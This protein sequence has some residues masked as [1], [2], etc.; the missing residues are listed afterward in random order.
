M[1]GEGSRQSSVC[2][3]L[4]LKMRVDTDTFIVIQ[5]HSM[6][7]ITR[8]VAIATMAGTEELKAGKGGRAP[9]H[10]SIIGISTANGSRSGGVGS[11]HN[12]HISRGH[13]CHRL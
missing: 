12:I 8:I 5:V 2:D 1:A 3:L 11:F 7:L 10:L 9:R 13:V 4:V 6:V